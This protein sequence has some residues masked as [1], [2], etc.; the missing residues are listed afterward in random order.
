M[1]Q[2]GLAPKGRSATVVVAS[3]TSRRRFNADLICDGVD[4]QDTINLAYSYLPAAGG[5]ILLLEGQF[6]QKK[7]VYPVAN[8]WIGGTGPGTTLKTSNASYSLL[9]ADK[10]LND[11][12]V[13][14]AD[15]SSFEVGQDCTIFDD[16][17]C[18][19]GAPGNGECVIITSIDGNT[20]HFTKTYGNAVAVTVGKNARIFS[21]FSN[22][23]IANVSDVRVSDMQI[24]GNSA[25][26]YQGNGDPFQN[27]ISMG[28]RG[29]GYSGYECRNKIYDCIIHD[30]PCG[31]ITQWAVP[32]HARHNTI[33]RNRI[34]SSGYGHPL[35]FHG[36]QESEVSKN[37]L[38]S[39]TAGIDPIT[40]YLYSCIDVDCIDNLMYPDPTAVSLSYGVWCQGTGYRN[41]ITGGL[42]KDAYTPFLF[43]T[44][45]SLLRSVHVKSARSDSSISSNATDLLI[46]NCRFE[47]CTASY[48]T[49]NPSV[50][51]VTIRD[52]KF[53]GQSGISI[54]GSASR[55]LRNTFE[56]QTG[57]AIQSTTGRFE[58]VGNKFIGMSDGAVVLMGACNHSIVSRNF[59]GMDCDQPGVEANTSDLYISEND[60]VHSIDGY[61]S[62]YMNSGTRNV[63]RENRVKRTLGNAVWYEASGG[64]YIIDNHFITPAT[65]TMALAAGSIVQRNRGYI[66]PGE[67]VTHRGSIATLTQ[68]AFNSVDNPFGQN[69]A[70]LSLDIYVS[71]GATATSPNID[72]G[73]GSSPTTDYTNLFDDLPGETIGLYNSKIATPGAQ[74]QPILWQSGAG[75]RYL[76][77]SMKDAAATGMVAT[78]V[79]TVMGL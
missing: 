22:I 59:F 53:S 24:D 37:I 19:P 61:A 38:G 2:Q 23:H 57:H 30:N 66:G 52:C 17:H 31:G 47:G 7:P 13:T 28:G 73:I 26:N 78:Y 12:Q 20:I 39:G 50:A 72:C 49:I 42:I 27:G 8:S 58:I 9:S 16:D 71:T 62:A 56:A 48:G 64:N 10:A 21:S 6:N 14:V 60:F 67:I 15:A 65:P 34:Y 11:L 45:S 40:L 29:G 68:D 43:G 70:L 51:G 76:N 18:T 3:S 25:N 5:K 69:V 44:A 55:I 32:D 35:H 54:A 46:E 4:D 33:L 75:N 41:R 77:M 36:L 74:T 1:A 79:A 63:F